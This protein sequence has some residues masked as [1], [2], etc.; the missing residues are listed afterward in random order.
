MLDVVL[1]VAW[2][3]PWGL[4]VLGWERHKRLFQS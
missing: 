3:R 4:R 1:S 2:E